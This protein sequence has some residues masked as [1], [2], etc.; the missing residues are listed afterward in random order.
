LSLVFVSIALLFVLITRVDLQDLASTI[1][2]YLETCGLKDQHR[3]QA[4]GL[5]ALIAFAEGD[6]STQPL[7]DE[8]HSMQLS[9]RTDTVSTDSG[10]ERSSIQSEDAEAQASSPERGSPQSSVSDLQDMVLPN[11]TRKLFARAADIIRKSRDLDGVMF[12]DASGKF[13]QYEIP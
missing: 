7:D 8:S 4:E 11:T 6:L 10:E 5:N 12:L 13:E 2:D 3:R 9:S 1:M